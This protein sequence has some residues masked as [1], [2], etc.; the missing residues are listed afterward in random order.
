MK[1]KPTRLQVATAKRLLS[2]GVSYF[3][4]GMTVGALAGAGWAM[5]G[6]IGAGAMLVRITIAFTKIY[7]R[8]GELPE[9]EI[10]KIIKQTI[11]ESP[12]DTTK[13]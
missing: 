9:T 11:D 7:A 12:K 6:A 2:L 8:D 3:L 4:S 13:K 1:L 5:S 10:D